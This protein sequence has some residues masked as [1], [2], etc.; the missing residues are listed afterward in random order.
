MRDQFDQWRGVVACQIADLELH[1]GFLRDN[2]DLYAAIDPADMQCGVGDVVGLVLR[3]VLDDRLLA[4]ANDTD[5]IAGEMHRV[6]RQWRQ[7]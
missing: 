6:D 3:A 5:Q 2:I 4:C 7:R 1:T